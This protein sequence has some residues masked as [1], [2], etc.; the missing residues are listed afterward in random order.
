MVYGP[1]RMH[2]LSTAGTP[3]EGGTAAVGNT[4]PK[5]LSTAPG[6]ASAAVRLLLQAIATPVL[7]VDSN[8]RICAANR[9]AESFFGY[10]SGELDG[11]PLSVVVPG[12]VA[13]R[14][15]HDVA[16][17]F[18]QPGTRPMGTG[19]DL[20]ARSRS[21][22]TIPVDIG[23]GHFEVDGSVFG[24]AFIVDISKRVETEQALLRRNRELDEFASVV[25]H[26]LNNMVAGIQ[27]MSEVLS[28]SHGDLAPEELSRHLQALSYR[29]RDLARVIRE[30]LIF[31]RLPK[32]GV[33]LE[34][35]HSRQTVV[36]A[37]SRLAV[38]IRDS[39]AA[40][41]ISPD[42]DDAVGYAPWVEEVWYNLVHNAIKYGGEPPEIR[43][44]S[45][46]DEGI[47]RFV[48]EDNGPGVP[49]E[50]LDSVFDPNDDRRG[51][52]VKGEGLGL[53]IVARIVEKLGGR[54]GIDLPEGGGSCFWFELPAE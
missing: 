4:D 1:G 13:T 51:R 28:E 14:H 29:T 34:R 35:F 46:P 16:H 22:A 5:E 30:L 7:V 3:A 37:V 18:D 25:A 8:A 21:G 53:G 19:L 6:S 50:L 27:G 42:L 33:Q 10:G 9:Q 38:D 40:I 41:D 24:L 17:F 49:Q 48:V 52:I 39:S 26:D 47:V 43:V 44:R 54:V 20:K 45:H 2:T 12:E 32:G 23:L 31:A 15:D 11:Q 36:H